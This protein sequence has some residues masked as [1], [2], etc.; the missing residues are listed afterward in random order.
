MSYNTNIVIVDIAPEVP[1]T[2]NGGWAEVHTVE[3]PNNRPHGG[4]PGLYV[5]RNVYTR[6]TVAYAVRM[7]LGNFTREVRESLDVRHH[8]CAQQRQQ[9]EAAE[10]ERVQHDIDAEKA[11]DAHYDR[12]DELGI[13]RR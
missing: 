4:T 12:L 3:C 5:N 11:Q 10:A 8:H 13:T 7:F 9:E 6:T 2:F 1:G